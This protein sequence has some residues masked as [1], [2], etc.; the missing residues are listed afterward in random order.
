MLFI[1]LWLKQ[2]KTCPNEQVFKCG[3]GQKVQSSM[4]GTLLEQGILNIEI[5][6]EVV[7]KRFGHREKLSFLVV[8]RW[9]TVSFLILCQ[10]DAVFLDYLLD[11]LS[12]GFLEAFIFK[13][14]KLRGLKQRI[15]FT[16]L[17][18][19]DKAFGFL[20]RISEIKKVETKI[21]IMKI[22]E[23]IVVQPHIFSTNHP[24]YI[25]IG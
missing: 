8:M 15:S 11:D 9:A 19:K 5:D 17:K 20:Y 13:F 6:P 7:E 24:Q 4:N 22:I 23:E 21:K 10:Q 3:R 25:L 14:A 1:N 18:N 12:S 2:K 16:K